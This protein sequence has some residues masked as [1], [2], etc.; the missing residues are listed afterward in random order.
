M[1]ITLPAAVVSSD[2]TGQTAVIFK[3]KITREM[4]VKTSSF[5]II[6]SLSVPYCPLV[7]W[8]RTLSAALSINPFSFWPFKKAA[9][10]LLLFSLTPRQTH[11]RGAKW[12]CWL[13]TNAFALINMLLFHTT[14]SCGVS[15][16]KVSC[17]GLP[18][19]PPV[20]FTSPPQ[21]SLPM[22]WDKKK[23]TVGFEDKGERLPAGGLV[24]ALV[25]SK[26]YVK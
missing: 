3:K 8:T 23:N 18:S 25:E 1:K 14:L 12:W 10:Q 16:F 22:R 21:D 4:C 17:G 20:K 9:A 15:H 2:N 6:E 26:D 13:H 24:V 5:T 11:I 19:S 7:L